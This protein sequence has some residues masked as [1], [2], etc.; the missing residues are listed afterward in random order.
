MNTSSWEPKAVPYQRWFFK[1]NATPL[2]LLVGWTYAREGTSRVQ[3]SIQ[4]VTHPELI[5]TETTIHPRPGGISTTRTEFSPLHTRGDVAHITWEFEITHVHAVLDPVAALPALIRVLPVS[6][7]I[8]SIPAAR[9]RGRLTYKGRSWEGEAWG[10]LAHYWGRS[11]P[12]HWFW[13]NSVLD[14]GKAFV[15]VLISELP[16]GRLPWPRG[17]MGYF[18]LRQRTQEYLW[19]HPFTGRVHIHGLPDQPL[20]R[21]TPWHGKGFRVLGRTHPKTWQK[22][23]GDIINSLTGEVHVPGVGDAYGVAAIE[24]RRPP[25]Y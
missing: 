9:F 1:L 3:I 12:P 25:V 13:L 24:W 8:L 11:R 14:G 7:R 21:A 5:Q 22:L 15:E 19:F 10:S 16:W 6:T 23:D 18:W 2:A 17:R 20:V 4:S